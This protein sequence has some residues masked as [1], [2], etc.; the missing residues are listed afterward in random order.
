MVP[1]QWSQ[2]FFSKI[3]FYFYN[4]IFGKRTITYELIYHYMPMWYCFEIIF[5][6]VDMRSI[7]YFCFRHPS[8]DLVSLQALPCS[9]VSLR[10]T[11][12]ESCSLSGYLNVFT[13]GVYCNYRAFF[14]RVWRRCPGFSMAV[15]ARSR[16]TLEWA[17]AYRGRC[18]RLTLA[19]TSEGSFLCIPQCGKMITG[20]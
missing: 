20:N 16:L 9:K 6:V 18:P 4:L 2:L 7:F 3:G 5:K 10:G 1:S 11:F 12:S 8:H 15:I 14:V 19:K 17:D 13:A